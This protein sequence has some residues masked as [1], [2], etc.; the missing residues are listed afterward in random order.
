MK[1]ERLLKPYKV[2]R[3]ALLLKPYRVTG[4][5]RATPAASTPERSER[6]APVAAR[7]SR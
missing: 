6:T 1:L 7:S 3:L 5:S 4:T 2:N